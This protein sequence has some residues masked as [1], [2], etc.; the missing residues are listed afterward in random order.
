MNKTTAEIESQPACWRRAAGLAAEPAVRAAL[1]DHGADAVVVGCGTSLF[2]AQSYAALREAAGLGRTDAF[3]ASEF[4]A[5]RPYPVVVAIS[6]SGT[7]SEVAALLARLPAHTSS[8]L[9]TA[10]AGSP[11]ARHA[12]DVILLDFADE[13]SVV[14]T[15]FA[16]TALVLL[17]AALGY[18]DAEGAARAAEAVLAAP[19]PLE[20]GTLDQITFLGSG[21]TVG[22]ASEAALKLRESAQ[23]WAEAYPVMEYRHGP[24]AIAQPGRAVW[25]FG[26]LPPGLADQITATGATIADTAGLEPLAALVLAQRFAAAEAAYRGLDQDRPRN[27]TRSVILPADGVTT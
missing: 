3:P 4:P 24:I 26:P 9:L 8:V 17:R 7:T 15:R 1:P 12:R 2:I 19:L 18:D 22:L 6:R 23:A 25:P 10:V 16:T 5:A 20:P 21:W 14:Q 27:L 11:C 13:E